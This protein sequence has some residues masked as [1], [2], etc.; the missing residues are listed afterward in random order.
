MKLLCEQVDKTHS[1]FYYYWVRRAGVFCDCLL[2][3]P[4]Q[5]MNRWASAFDFRRYDPDPS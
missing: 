4:F 5:M 2:I 3:T 1:A